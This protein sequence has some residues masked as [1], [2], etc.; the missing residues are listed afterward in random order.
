MYWTLQIIPP[1]DS[2]I[3]GASAFDD[4]L[5]VELESALWKSL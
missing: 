5:D 2:A 4:G 1:L 3:E